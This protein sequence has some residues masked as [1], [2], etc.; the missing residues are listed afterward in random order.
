MQ[1][2]RFLELHVADGCNLSCESCAHFAGYLSGGLL[3]PEDAESQMAAW[4]ARLRPGVFNIFGGEPCLNPD[5]IPIIELALQ[6][7]PG[8]ARQVVSNG[9]LLSSVPGL[10]VALAS[11]GTG[12]V[13]TRHAPGDPIEWGELKKIIGQGAR[14][15]LLCADGGPPPDGFSG[16][17]RTKQWTRRYDDVGGRPVPDPGGDP[18]QVWPH[19]PCRGFFQLRGGMLYKCPTVAYLPAVQ[20]KLG[21]L[22]PGWG[23]ALAYAPLPSTCTDD[24]LI[25]FLSEKDNPACAACSLSPLPL[26][27]GNP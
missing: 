14:V 15:T 25:T 26:T 20:S 22:D 13:V 4:S 16:V 23:P 6:Y 5:L 21:A 18:S 8:S 9:T 11:T 17:V 2:C 7:W 19:C 12:L 3:S 24:E 1:S 27:P 10:G